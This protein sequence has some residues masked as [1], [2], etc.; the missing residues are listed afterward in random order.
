VWVAGGLV[1][2]VLS[3]QLGYEC[4]CRRTYSMCACHLVCRWHQGTR[5]G[6]LHASESIDFFVSWF[7]VPL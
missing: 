7:F 1:D 5:F 4:L 6:W 2:M 3:A